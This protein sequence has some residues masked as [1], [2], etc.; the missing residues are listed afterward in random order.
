MRSSTNSIQ[1]LEIFSF[2]I[3][4][5]WYYVIHIVFIEEHLEVA[6]SKVADT[7]GYKEAGGTLW[8]YFVEYNEVLFEQCL[9]VEHLSGEWRRRM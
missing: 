7:F 1:G 2:H 3:Q 5:L 8:D 6:R 4:T 9:R